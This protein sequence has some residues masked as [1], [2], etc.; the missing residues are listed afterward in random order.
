MLL[1]LLT[2][3]FAA[4]VLLFLWALTKPLQLTISAVVQGFSVTL[5]I[6]VDYGRVHRGHTWHLPVTPPKSDRPRPR[7]KLTPKIIDDA[8]WAFGVLDRLTYRLWNRMKVTQFDLTAEI[9]LNDAAETA[10]W[11]GRAA[12]VLGWWISI[13]VAPRSTRPPRWQVVPRWDA[14][15]LLCNFTSI[16]QLQPSDII[17]AIVYGLWGQVKGGQKRYGHSVQELGHA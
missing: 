12:Q 14:P 5:T 16:I 7:L 1:V 3:G 9:G 17:L 8:V 15:I 11:M 4:T 13:R 10:L 2:I 6:A